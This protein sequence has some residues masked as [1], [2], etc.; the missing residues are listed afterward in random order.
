M[1]GNANQNKLYMEFPS[2]NCVSSSVAPLYIINLIKSEFE[3]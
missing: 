2:S 3:W 1:E